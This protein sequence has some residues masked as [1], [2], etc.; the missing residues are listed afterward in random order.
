M[1]DDERQVSP[2][3]ARWRRLWP[4]AIIVASVLAVFGQVAGFGFVNFDDTQFITENPVVRSGLSAV[5]LRWA[6]TAVV[7]GNWIPVTWLSHLADV[8]LFGLWA[9]GH[10]L[11][12]LL[13]HLVNAL[14]VFRL[15]AAITGNRT[16][17]FLAALIFAVHPLNVEP[18]AWVSQR[19]TL[20]MTLFGL[21]AAHAWSRYLRRPATGSYLLALLLFALGLLAKPLLVTLPVL[22]L[23]LDVWPF[24]RWP[25]RTGG[26]AAAA[27][28]PPWRLV[29]E[30]VPFLALSVAIG[31]VALRTQA[32]AM[33]L[34]PPFGLGARAAH[35]AV[36]G[37]WYLG[38]VFWPAP[39]AVFYPYPMAGD[40]APLVFGAATALLFV[41]AVAIA[42]RGRMPA[43]AVGWAWFVV[44]LLP[45]SGILQV[46]EQ[47]WADRYAYLPLTGLLLA[48]AGAFPSDWLRRSRT[49]RLAAG[50]AT[51]AVLALGAVSF[52]QARHW[53]DG[54][55]LFTHALEVTA[56]NYMAYNNLGSLL[57]K[58]GDLAGAARHFGESIRFAPRTAR[59]HRN[60]GLVRLGQGDSAGA[61]EEF[62]NA[63]RENPA[64]AREHRDLVRA[65][66]R[67]GRHREAAAVCREAARV[68]PGDP[69]TRKICERLE[70]SNPTLHGP[71]P[72]PP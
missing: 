13:A 18:L 45:V 44:S 7:G 19:R 65:L 42:L 50:V 29:L 71:S 59:P 53:R 10:H 27:H 4:E 43:L 8:R 57:V 39:L 2:A 26:R 11:V 9:G 3:R 60:L 35:A 48:L 49:V 28:G 41:T 58:E 6:L 47:A 40:P 17:S 31:V 36:S 37:A 66:E 32:G 33:T 5:S 55:T 14:L 51:G 1:T 34:L 54:R 30:K 21:L 16:G 67:L 61:A 69:V 12:N 72:L 25:A 63:V 46:G 64:D 68:N 15:L 20:L 56:G 22:L 62:L 70:A 23:L 24:R 52:A 38:K